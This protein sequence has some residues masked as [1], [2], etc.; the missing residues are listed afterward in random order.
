MSIMINKG[1]ET[2]N[3]NMKIKGII[4]RFICL[5]IALFTINT[6]FAQYETI[7][8]DI[9][10]D[11]PEKYQ[12]R[13]LKSEK[14]GDKKLHG[15]KK[16]MQN[17]V[18]H[19]NYYFNANNRLHQVIDRARISNKDNYLELLPFYDYSLKATSA[20]KSDLDSVIYKATLGIL[21]HDLRNNWVDD[22][23]MLIGEAYYFRKDFDSASM[24]FQFINYNLS[25]RGKDYDEN[26]GSSNDKSTGLTIANKEKK[27]FMTGK[28]PARNDALLWQI[29]TSIDKE[30]FPEAAGLINTLQND[31]N[32]PKRLKEGLEEVTAY[33]FYQQK[34]YDS[35][36]IHLER[37][38]GTA[39]NKQGKAR[40]EFLLAQL[41]EI[42][43]QA[44]RAE[45]Y[46]AKAAKHTN[47]PLMDIYANLS[48]AKMYKGNGGKDIDNNIQQLLHL[49]HRGKYET[50]RDVVYF[51]AGELAL[52]KPDTTAAELYYKKSVS[53]NT[54]NTSVKNR[55]FLQ[56]ADIAFD[57]KDYKHASM[58]YDSLQLTDPVFITADIQKIK[59]R[60]N[61]LAGIVEKITAIEREDSLQKV[62]AM[63]PV[64]RE[65]FVK[66]LLKKIRKEKGLK[67]EA[68]SSNPGPFD[69]NK[70]TSVDLFGGNNN[71]EW[72]FYNSSAKSKGFSDFKTT[73]G[74]RD[75]VDN[76]RRK[77]G[78]PVNTFNSNPDAVIDVPNPKGPGKNG[79]KDNSD[80]GDDTYEGLM[81]HLPLTPD[82]LTLSNAT[83]A[84][85][86][87]Q[88]G[89]LYL[90]LEEYKAAAQTYETSLT[91]FPDSLYGGLLY[92]NTYYSYNK[93]GNVPKADYYKGLL[94][95]KFK[96][97][98]YADAVLNPNKGKEQGKNSVAT[99]RYESIYNLFIEGNFTEAVQQKKTAD[100]LYGKTYWN[101]QL[102]Y[103]EAV[104]YVK[105]KQDSQAI[106][107]LNNIV[108]LYPS[109][110]LKAKAVTLIDVLKR[111][112]DIEAYL[113]NLNVQ[114][115]PDSVVV[116]KPTQVNNPAPN[117]PN[118][119][120]DNNNIAPNGLP[121]INDAPSQ[122]TFTPETPHLVVM[123]LDKVD[124][125]YS[126]EAKGA[127]SRYNSGRFP[128]K[129]ITIAKEQ[130]DNDKTLLVF[131]QFTNA[132]DAISYIASLKSEATS[133][134]SWLPANKYYYIV[135]SE[136]NLSILRNNK[137]L[138]GYLD[139]L[140]SKYPGKF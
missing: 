125:V 34:M 84:S 1:L 9:E 40:M 69:N 37:S 7:Q 92:M 85:S 11:K 21:L 15:T 10:K 80:L 106:K 87:F 82:K 99:K 127:F 47:D 2:M 100:S 88:L 17:M 116:N 122:F 111:R 63:V 105:Q 140:R 16:A 134:I 108:S 43:K 76:W 123:V 79:N 20:Q 42:S 18:T 126:T 26:V 70:N 57:K 93:L 58:Y 31:E 48:S 30:E 138:K 19:Y 41:F 24:T 113:G 68:G 38:L 89:N 27:G 4:R 61:A 115:K 112:K 130:L 128:E 119:E 78:S 32:F 71:A 39:D 44:D 94:G 121:T 103:I 3:K 60:T 90:N 53:Y 62:A 139:L 35:A 28:K 23:Y 51:S 91:R 133:Q 107:V 59:D 95:S 137:N 75:N 14:T 56:L 25:P 64:E 102:L 118:K 86:T 74:K 13:T 49:A 104:Y 72:Y 117:N 67:D 109:S 135:I 12:N 83:L 96:D 120:K 5:S 136:S 73:W 22:L 33:W 6:L 29:R 101:P 46:Y 129:N 114:R 81:S 55:A 110:P 77:Q 8:E 97:T 65:K 45:K 131:T 52:K 98:K 54:T 50:Y 132:D 66:A 124:A 36:A